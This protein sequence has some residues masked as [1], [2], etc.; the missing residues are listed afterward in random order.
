[1]YDFIEFFG[2]ELVAGRGFSRNRPT[3]QQA[4]VINETLARKIGW[5]P[6]QALGKQTSLGED[7]YGQV[8]GVV[9]DF[10]YS[11]VIDPI[12]PLALMPSSTRLNN[13]LMRTRPGSL[14][15]GLDHI[16]K[17]WQAFF[18]DKPFEYIFL[19]QEFARRYE[20]YEQQTLIIG[21][22]TLLAVL[23]ACLGL[24]GLTTQAAESR[25]KE[26]GV[27]KALGASVADIILLLSRE[28]LMLLAI[29]ILIAWPVAWY[30][31]NRW[32]QNF[33]YRIDLDWYTFV[34]AGFIALTVAGATVSY[35][36]LKAATAD[37]VKALRYE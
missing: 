7:L 36:A 18:P 9:K 8:I 34:L 26:I 5:S 29:S 11:S 33:A 24:L 10:N 28:F 12:E 14:T 31:A 22:F 16:Q 27:R 20:S 21:T 35:Q 23:L 4:Y 3:D 1:D 32:L 17:Q 25:T 15:P 19:D 13:V 6:Q 37:P 2:L 30:F